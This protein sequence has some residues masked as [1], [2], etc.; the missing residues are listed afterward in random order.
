MTPSISLSE[1][2]VIFAAGAEVWLVFLFSARILFRLQVQRTIV[3]CY[4]CFSLFFLLRLCRSFWTALG[5]NLREHECLLWD[6]QH[7][8]LPSF[9]IS[10]RFSGCVKVGPRCSSLKIKKVYSNQQKGAWT[11]GAAEP[12]LKNTL[13]MKTT[14]NKTRL[15]KKTTLWQTVTMRQ[16]SKLRCGNCGMRGR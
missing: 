7:F 16:E 13:T 10:V 8:Y 11:K 15:W 12:D 6:W 14:I 4:L 2:I 5:Q 3:A 1:L 9:I